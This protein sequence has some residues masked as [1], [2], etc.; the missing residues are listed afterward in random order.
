LATRPDDVCDG[1]VAW[2]MRCCLT[3]LDVTMQIITLY[4]GKTVE[5]NNTDAEGRLVLGDGVAYAVKHLSP[6]IIFDMATLTGA[7]GIA[8]GQRHAGI[9]C[10]NDELEKQVIASGKTSGNLVHPV[11][12]CWLVLLVQSFSTVAV[13]SCMCPLCFDAQLVY[14]PGLRSLISSRV[15]T[16]C[17]SV[18]VVLC[19]FPNRVSPQGV[20]VRGC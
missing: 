19:G 18:L 10:N 9:F 6:D 20:R 3:S 12:A 5:V 13:C 15:S 4:S 8:T 11:S 16:P 14:C 1:L 2:R 17:K 7:Q